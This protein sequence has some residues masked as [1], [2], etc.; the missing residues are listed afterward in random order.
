[1]M[2]A[3]MRTRLTE[4]SPSIIEKIIESAQSGDMTAARLVMERL[5][6]VRKASS[7]PAVIDGLEAADGLSTQHHL[8]L[9][10]LTKL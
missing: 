7:E 1:M 6:P 4:A 8:L 9:I 5:A 10:L 3:E 2:P